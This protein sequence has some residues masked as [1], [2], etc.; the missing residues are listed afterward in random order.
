MKPVPPWVTRGWQSVRVMA[1]ILLT[2][3]A[4]A[5]F[6]VVA[7]SMLSRDRLVH[8]TKKAFANGE[9]AFA[10]R[11]NEDFF[12]ECSMLTMQYLRRDGAVLST[13]DNQFA[14]SEKYHPCEVLRI[15]V[16]EEPRDDS[17]TFYSYLN[18]PYGSRH[19]E[20]LVLSMMDYA[21]A[22][23][24]YC[25]LSYGSIVF[26]LL[27]AWRNSSSTALLV[28]PVGTFL[29]FGFEFTTFG[30]NLGHAPGYFVGFF[31][32]GVFLAAR[33]WFNKASR[34]FVFFGVLGALLAYFDILTG[35]IQVV[36][37]L[38]IVLNH[39]FYVANDRHSRGYWTCA[40]RQ[41]VAIVGCFLIAY[42]VLTA[43]R[44]V[45]ASLYH[46]GG[47]YDIRHILG[48][49]S[50]QGVPGLALRDLI[51]ALWVAR[52]RLTGN[53][54]TATWLICAAAAA[55]ILTLFSILAVFI[56]RRAISRDLITDL[57]IILLASWGVISWYLMF[58]G[59]SFIHVSFMVRIVALPAAYGFIAATLA[60]QSFWD[61][62]D[63]RAILI[64]TGMAAASFL[65][66]ANLMHSVW[67]LG[68]GPEILSA[69][70]S[71]EISDKVSCAVL[72]L[73]SDGTSD[74]LIEFV[75]RSRHSKS[76]LAWLRLRKDAPKPIYVALQR[77][78]PAATYET[79]SKFYLLGI[80]ATPDGSLLNRAD[81]SFV[82]PASF[83]QAGH[84]LWAHFC[85]CCGDT[86]ESIYELCVGSQRVQASGP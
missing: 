69:R 14:R 21:A 34:R 59:H 60:A 81:G 51:M 66:A 36:A 42:L 70:F 15:L 79:G 26:L 49:M 64:T 52:F 37:S 11:T 5:I 31:A 55:W 83:G 33:E 45:A 75:L 85:R 72:G 29:L 80:S 53:A 18:Y 56:K 57:F 8:V 65:L 61:E 58:R 73:Q 2:I 50:G 25:I 20:A 16:N 6:S 13:V 17:I 82:V 76:P 67:N 27:C 41:A 39:L 84:H 74:G 30:D 44:M 46:L 68:I 28:V 78:N 19:L 35:S 38:A 62:W 22:K 48:Y 24:L 3:C 47:F 63:R 32:L 43:T 12:T 54:L 71:Q 86:P 77:S 1:G 7:E 9:L 4:L 40:T 23:T 10:T